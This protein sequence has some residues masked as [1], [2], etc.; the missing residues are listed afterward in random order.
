ML[1]EL[2]AK[3]LRRALA[4]VVSPVVVFP[5]AEG[6]R[7]EIPKNPEIHR[8]SLQRIQMSQRIHQRSLQRIQTRPGLM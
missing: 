2:Y 3:M 8:K 1:K 4:A 7:Q 5:A 6:G